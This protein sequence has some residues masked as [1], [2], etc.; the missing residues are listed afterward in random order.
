MLLDL[1][2]DKSGCI[3]AAANISGGGAASACAAHATQLEGCAHPELAHGNFRLVMGCAAASALRPAFVGA[4]RH[5]QHAV[6]G[7]S[8]RPFRGIR[9]SPACV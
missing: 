9:F 7:F 4:F 5:M 8:A 2:T 6:C 1:T 3:V